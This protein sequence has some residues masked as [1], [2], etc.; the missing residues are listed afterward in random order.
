VTRRRITL[1][2]LPTGVLLALAVVMVWLL[3]TEAGARWIWARATAALPGLQAEALSG[4]LESGLEL[5]GLVYTDGALAVA[6]DRVRLQLAFDL[7]PP[8]VVIESLDA[9]RLDVRTGAAAPADAATDRAATLGALRL[10]LPLRFEQVTLTTLAFHG[11]VRPRALEIHD[12]S[13]SGRWQERLEL[14]AMRLRYGGLRLDGAARLDLAPPFPL[15]AEAAAEFPGA[16]LTDDGMP[17]MLRAQIEG[18]LG[19]L[20]VTAG[21]ENAD[22]R[23]EGDLR[24]VL[25]DPHWNLELQSERLPLQAGDTAIEARRL[26]ATSSGSAAGYRIELAAGLAVTGLPPL[27]LAANGSGDRQGLTIEHAQ[28]ENG[29]VGLTATGRVDWTQDLRVTATA[30]VAGFDPRPWI[31]DWPEAHP[32]DGVFALE[33]AG[34]EV[35]VPRLQLTAAGTPF[36][37]DGRA[38]LDPAADRVSGTLEWQEFSWPLG[39]DH[40]ALASRAGTL[41]LAGRPDDWTASGTVRLQAAGVPEG[42]LRLSA[43]GNLESLQAEI[44]KGAILGGTFAGSFDYRWAES[45]AWSVRVAAQSLRT[46]PLLPGYP[47]VISGRVNV[48]ARSGPDQ[49]DIKIEQLDGVIR[50]RP[51]QANG[52][53]IIAG[54]ILQADAVTIRSGES[55][56]RLDGNPRG[57]D[58]LAFD[59]RIESLADFLDNAQGRAEA[60]GRLALDSAQPRLELELE[61]QDLAWMNWRAVA[62][63]VQHNG[64]RGEKSGH[65]VQITE[66]AIGDYRVDQAELSWDGRTPLERIRADASIRGTRLTIA[67]QGGVQDWSR[68]LRSGWHG[69]MEELR[70]ERGTLGVLELRAPAALSAGTS[71]ARLEPACFQSQQNGEICLRADW[72]ERGDLAVRADLE[73]ISLDLV[74]LFAATNVAFSQ[75]LTGSL[76]WRQPARGDATGEVRI[77]VSPGELS[78]PEDEETVLRTGAGILEFAIHGGQLQAGNFDIPVIGGG[79]IDTSFSLPDLSRGAASPVDARILVELSDIAPIALLFPALD[80]VE[81][82]I[83]ADLRVGGTLSDPVL[84]GHA[85]LVRGRIEHVATGLVLS[86]IQLAGAVYEHGFTELNGVFRAGDGRGRIKADLGFGDRLKP[87][88]KLELSGHDLLLVNVPDMRLVADPDL[89]LAWHGGPIDIDGRIQVSSARLSPRY[90]PTS[91]VTESPDLV[92]VAGQGPEP[93]EAGFDESRLRLNGSVEVI[94]GEDVNVKLERATAHFGGK[95]VFLWQDQL[96]PIGDGS[97]TVTGEIQA[98]GQLLRISEGRIRFPRKPANNPTLDIRAEREIY[99]NRQIKAAGVHISGTLK[100]PLL[101]TY[102]EPP[103]TQERALTLLVTGNDFDYEQGVGAVEVGTYVARKLYVSYGIGLFDNQNVISARYDLKKGFGIKATSGQR[104]T[105]VDISYTIDH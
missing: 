69:R 47:G 62:M 11:P 96:M 39:S 49:I 75:R 60:Q 35:H 37:L 100:R 8:A 17:L 56:I 93:A 58:G 94:L 52:S 54:G 32:L 1:L 77:R 46:G 53:V 9:G 28:I 103:T 99:G 31:P 13:I 24:E 42:E 43:S 105:G 64:M 85:T 30:T 78:L 104:E 71:A 91:T 3:H 57:P 89:R 50:D 12:L 80:R 59:A 90:L 48:Q 73:G 40:P 41:E 83:S 76:D 2:F 23:L 82:Q 4:D 55:E 101:E 26:T 61:A 21:A 5:R 72:E 27:E 63:T 86:D 92:I 66:A 88:V 97:Y 65:R 20:R 6:A 81:G 7:L 98:Y 10:P 25:T 18:D 84:T 33:W 70:A 36:Q 74:R 29:A 14:R 15:T 87:E 22:V 19:L 67:L 16:G 95:V 51:V 45:P 38:E 102:T 68:P 79:G 44:E 34:A